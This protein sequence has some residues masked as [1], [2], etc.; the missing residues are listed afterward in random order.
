MVLQTISID[1]GQTNNYNTTL[2]TEAQITPII[3]IIINNKV[4]AMYRNIT[5]D[6]PVGNVFKVSKTN[7]T[8]EYMLILTFEKMD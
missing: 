6:K 4:N 1:L 8:N 5:V 2:K 7:N 3:G